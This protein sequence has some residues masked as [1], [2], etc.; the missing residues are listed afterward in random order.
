MPGAIQEVLLEAGPGAWRF[1]SAAPD[2]TLSGRV[3]EFWE[4]EGALKPFRETLLPN[5]CVELMVNLGPPHTLLSEQGVGV[6]KRAWFSGLHEHALIIESLQGTHLVSA[7]MDPLA[8]RELLGESVS[9]CANKVVDLETFLGDDGRDLVEGVRAAGSV[10][11]RFTVFE[12]LLK[13]RL[14]TAEP[15]PEFVRLCAEK[16]VSA[17]GTLHVST[18]YQGVGVSRKHLAVSFPRYFG[19]PTKSYAKLQ[20]F[21]WTLERLRESSTVDWSRLALDA[22][23]SDQS[24]LVRDFQR[25]GAASPTEYLRTVSPDGTALLAEPG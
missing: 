2:S 3:E 6:W 4:V 15:A 24:H 7:R 17:H 21:V 10:A 19:I 11:A 14:L 8:A 20:R 13:R 23:Y 25:I 9:R 16:I 22:G 18:L 12:D 5:G 1:S